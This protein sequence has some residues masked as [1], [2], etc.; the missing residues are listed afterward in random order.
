MAE[1]L[2]AALE[3]QPLNDV[4][5]CGIFDDRSNDRSPPMIAGYPKLGTVARNWSSSVGSPGSTS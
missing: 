3:A 1:D 5:I 2:I 4:R